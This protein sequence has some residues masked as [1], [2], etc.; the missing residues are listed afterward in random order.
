MN[1]QL[2]VLCDVPEVVQKM[3]FST[4]FEPGEYPKTSWESLGTP[5]GHKIDF[6]SIFGG[7][8]TGF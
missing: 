3:N 5:P 6:S 2:S 8:W 4:L 1:M 7:P